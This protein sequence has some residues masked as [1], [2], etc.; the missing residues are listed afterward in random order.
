MNA[1]LDGLRSQFRFNAQR[2]QTLV[3]RAGEARI[4]VRPGP[5]S[6]SAAECLVHL[7]LSTKMYFPVWRDAFADARSRNILENGRLFRMDFAG[8][9]LHWILRPSARLRAKAPSKLQPTATDDALQRF[10]ASQDQLLA[11]VAEWD[12]LAVDRIKIASPAISI[13]HYSVWSSFR[14]IENHQR[15]HL[16]QAERAAGLSE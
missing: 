9:A 3:S 10:L 11:V 8:A 5:D 16:L 4:A 7:T 12:G 13:V 15:R 2:A 14:V 1:Q 6:W